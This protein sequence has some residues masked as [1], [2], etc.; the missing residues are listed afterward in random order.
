MFLSFLGGAGC[1]LSDFWGVPEEL[2][3]SLE[4]EKRRCAE[5]GGVGG[6]SLW[7]GV[8]QLFVACGCRSQENKETMQKD[9]QKT[10]ME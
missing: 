2:Q 8:M 1:F 3:E 9:H 5:A 4:D 10:S 6:R 7:E